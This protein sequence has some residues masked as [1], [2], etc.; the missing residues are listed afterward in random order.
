MEPKNYR[1]EIEEI[2]ELK[3]NRKIFKGKV[4]G[5]LDIS[6]DKKTPED[7]YIIHLNRKLLGIFSSKLKGSSSDYTFQFSCTSFY[8]LITE[9]QY[10]RMYA[11]YKDL[12]INNINLLIRFPSDFQINSELSL[13]EYYRIIL[14]EIKDINRLVNLPRI[15]TGSFDF[16]C[17]IK[18]YDT[19]EEKTYKGKCP[20]IYRLIASLEVIRN[21]LAIKGKYINYIDIKLKDLDDSRVTYRESVMKRKD[22]RA[23]REI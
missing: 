19:D 16:L 4:T 20:S 11:K 23:Q 12:K 5:L 13:E 10:I 2:N 18:I 21:S 15:F 3:K 1:Q 8:K 7:F 9:L 14:E 6:F 22:E 17:T